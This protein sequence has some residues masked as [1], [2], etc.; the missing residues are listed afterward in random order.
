VMTP[1]MGILGVSLPGC[2]DAPAAILD[3]SPSV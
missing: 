3:N 1:Y 2:D